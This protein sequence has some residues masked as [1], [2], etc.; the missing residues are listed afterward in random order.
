MRR[1]KGYF[2]SGT[3]LILVLMLTGGCSLFQRRGYVPNKDINHPGKLMSRKSSRNYVPR[4]HTS[5]PR[6]GKK[7]SSTKYMYHDPVNNKPSASSYDGKPFKPN[8]N[9]DYSSGTNRVKEK[10]VND[11]QYRNAYKYDNYGAKNRK[12]FK[13]R[14]KRTKK[15]W[16]FGLF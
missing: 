1:F 6:G 8:M 7:A 14:R 2:L 3:L 15:K 11:I 12:H 9:I 13:N 4:K 5:Y 16:F 10:R